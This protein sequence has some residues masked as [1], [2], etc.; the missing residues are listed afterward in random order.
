MRNEYTQRFFY[1]FFKRGNPRTKRSNLIKEVCNLLTLYWGLLNSVLSPPP[2]K[3]EIENEEVHVPC[4]VSH[5]WMPVPLLCRKGE[6]KHKIWKEQ[7]NMPIFSNGKSMY[8]GLG[9]DQT[10]LAPLLLHTIQLCTCNLRPLPPRIL[11][12]TEQHISNTAVTGTSLQRS[13]SQFPCL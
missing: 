12:M 7:H 3:R 5:I 10:V 1:I 13:G 11:E 2:K 9:S 6:P 8:W 4:F